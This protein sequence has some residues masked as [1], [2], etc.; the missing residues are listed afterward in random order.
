MNML[1][2]GELCELVQCFGKQLCH[3]MYILY[4]TLKPCSRLL[5]SSNGRVLLEFFGFVF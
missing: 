2:L 4:K 1:Q 3:I 5:S